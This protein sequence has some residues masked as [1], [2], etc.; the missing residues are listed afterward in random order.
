MSV[1]AIFSIHHS[2]LRGRSVTTDVAIFSIQHSSLRGR[3]VTTDVAIFREKRTL[4]DWI[5]RLTRTFAE[6]GL[7]RE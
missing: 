3:S 1:V 5:L 6:V 2:S 7:E 4:R